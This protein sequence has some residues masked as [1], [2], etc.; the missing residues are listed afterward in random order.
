MRKI[1]LF[2]IIIAGYV[3]S[4][5]LFLLAQIG[6]ATVLILT[7]CLIILT[8]PFTTICFALSKERTLNW[9]DKNIMGGPPKNITG[10][11][12]GF[13]PPIPPKKQLKITPHGPIP[14]FK[15]PFG[16]KPDLP[17]FLKP[18]QKPRW[19]QDHEE[20]YGDEYEN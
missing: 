14:P 3:V 10:F 9:I 13:P 7:A 2:P 5:L 18:F 11:P 1:L 15:P 19:L 4:V 16:G 20:L 17:P 8:M 6:I 12:P